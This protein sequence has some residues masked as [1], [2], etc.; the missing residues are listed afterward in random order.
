[1]K[2][3][4]AKRFLNKKIE[5]NNAVVKEARKSGD[6]NLIELTNDLDTESQAI[7]TLLQALE[8]SVSKEVIRKK[9]KNLDEIIEESKRGHRNTLI[10]ATIVRH[11]LQELL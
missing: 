1:M 3:E 11:E 6:I 2:L 9:I 5:V 4:E 10:E 8:N 7:E